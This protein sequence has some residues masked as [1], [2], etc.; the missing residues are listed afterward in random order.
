MSQQMR[1]N[2][3]CLC[4]DVKFTAEPLEPHV[5]VCHCIMCRRWSGGIF[6][7]VNCG[8]SVEVEDDKSLKAFRSSEWGERLFCSTCGTSLF[9][10]SVQD[11]MT[12]VSMQAFENPEPFAL[13]KE[14]F[15]DEKP[16]NYDFSNKTH[17][18]TGKE[19]LA[20]IGVEEA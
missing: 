2:G 8:S 4:G 17:H 9:W 16:A 5:E 11:R 6:L 14:I 19:F 20:S 13:T 10:R 3:Q 12:V 18:M 1:L 15:I 7:G